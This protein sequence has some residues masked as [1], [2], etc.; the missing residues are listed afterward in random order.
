MVVPLS[1]REHRAMRARHDPIGMLD[2]C[3]LC[4]LNWRAAPSQDGFAHEKHYLSTIPIQLILIQHVPNL[5]NSALDSLAR[6]AQDL[7]A[8]AMR[9]CSHARK[10]CSISSCVAVWYIDSIVWPSSVKAMCRQGTGFV[11]CSR[12]TKPI[13]GHRLHMDFASVEGCRQCGPSSNMSGAD[14]RFGESP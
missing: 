2:L 9:R 4:L 7:C 8:S 11:R 13:R 5:H 10:D 3:Q 14:Q 1:R 12:G 6:S